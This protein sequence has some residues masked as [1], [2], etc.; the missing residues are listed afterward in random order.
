LCVWV[1][2]EKKNEK[3]K[4]GA[5]GA[6][7]CVKK[8]AV[9]RPRVCDWA[10][11]GKAFPTKQGLE[12]HYR[13]HTHEKPY[14][15]EWAGCGKRFSVKSSLTRHTRIHTGERPFVCREEGCGRSFRH[16]SHLTDHIRIHT[17]DKPYAC[18]CGKEFRQSGLFKRH[19]AAHFPHLRHPC[20]WEGCCQYFLAKGELTLH[21]RTHTGE[22]PYACTWPGCDKWFRQTGHVAVHVAQCHT[23]EKRHACAWPGCE[24]RCVRAGNL[25]SHL[26]VHSDERPVRCELW[27]CDRMFKTFREMMFHYDTHRLIGNR[28]RCTVEGCGQWFQTQGTLKWHRQ[29]QHRQAG[30]VKEGGKRKAGSSGGGEV[31]AKRRRK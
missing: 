29:T 26:R 21:M 18:P 6:D 23:H 13:S 14:E 3:R 15:C 8:Q 19:Q 2:E 27:E 20:P 9:G 16:K 11:C 17:G 10:G 1:C 25:K 22:R 24:Y 7:G 30:G 5:G 28:H 12:V 31:Q 4:R